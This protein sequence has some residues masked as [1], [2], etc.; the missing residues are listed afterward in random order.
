MEIDHELKEAIRKAIDR[1]IPKIT[2]CR[3]DE[4]K[5]QYRREKLLTEIT[6][7]YTLRQNKDLNATQPTAGS[8]QRAAI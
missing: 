7:L 5:A 2:N 3:I 4:S 8:V 1:A 6:V